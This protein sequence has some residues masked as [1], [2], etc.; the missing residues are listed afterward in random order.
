[1]ACELPAQVPE[2]QVAVTVPE[3]GLPEE[4]SESA[5]LFSAT[6]TT[7]G[8]VDPPETVSHGTDA[9]VEKVIF[10]ET[11]LDATPTVSAEGGA[12]VPE[13]IENERLDAASTRSAD[14]GRTFRL[15]PNKPEAGGMAESVTLIVKL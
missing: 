7:P 1:M 9:E 12:E 3:Y 8:V 4:F 11:T 14:C 6:E 2:L 10:C 15:A 13:V 5:A